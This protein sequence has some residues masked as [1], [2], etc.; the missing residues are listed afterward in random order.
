MKLQ[1]VSMVAPSQAVRRQ[2]RALIL[3]LTEGKFTLAELRRRLLELD[4]G[5]PLALY[6]EAMS[7]WDAGDLETA[8]DFMWRCLWSMPLD[9]RPL[10]GMYAL[11]LG[12]DQQ[13]TEELLVLAM[14]HYAEQAPELKIVEEL[15]RN[16]P[17][18]APVRLLL[19]DESALARMN[20]KMAEMRGGEAPELV[21]FWAADHL[22]DVMGDPEDE[23]LVERMLA[24]PE[25]YA[26]V[27]RGLCS[28]SGGEFNPGP[29]AFS[30]SSALA[31]LG[32]MGRMEDVPWVAERCSDE[33]RQ[34]RNT[35]IW[36][37][38]R[39]GSRQEREF[40][41]QLK[42]GVEGRNGWPLSALTGQ[43]WMRHG[44]RGMEP[45]LL[46]LLAGREGDEDWEYDFN[47]PPVV[48]ALLRLD[49]RRNKRVVREALK[50]RGSRLGEAAQRLVSELLSDE[51]ECNPVWASEDFV[52]APLKEVLF[53]DVLEILA[54]ES[55]LAQELGGGEEEYEDEY[56][57]DEVGPVAVARPGRNEPCWCGSGK[58]YK[59]C[60]LASDEAG[61]VEDEAALTS[62][63][64]RFAMENVR[65][66][67]MGPEM[68]RFGEHLP[69]DPNEM[70]DYFFQWLIY[71]YHCKPLGGSVVDTY[72]KRHAQSDEERALL[73][74][75]GETTVAVYEVQ[76]ARLDEGLELLD[77]MRQT[78]VFVH[79]T[80]TSR[81]LSRYDYLL[82]RLE[83]VDGQWL[84]Q[85]DLMSVPRTVAPEVLRRL[86]GEQRLGESWD[87]TLKRTAPELWRWVVDGADAAAKGLKFTTSTGEGLEM[88]RGVYEL[89]DEE[90]VKAALR[91]G[92][93]MHEEEGGT[94]AWV[95]P[96]SGVVLGYMRIR[97]E[98]MVVET[99]SRQRLE[100]SAALLRELAPGPELVHIKDEFEKVDLAK[101][102]EMP[103][104]APQPAESIAG[105]E[106][107]MMA[108]F[109]RHYSSWPDLE[110]PALD[111]RTPREAVKSA[112]G[113]A[114]VET[115]LRDF[116]NASAKEK[117]QGRTAYDFS[118][119]RRELG[120][121]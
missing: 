24:Q 88:C 53:E 64:M 118:K 49:R 18:D 2:C 16:L 115:L 86:R 95:E 51:M 6:G 90:G 112:E 69:P 21:P 59:K 93:M 15:T 96:E 81:K 4:P 13:F 20:E 107:M 10:F 52:Q 78:R 74:S 34:V 40:R 30:V 46:K 117:A 3:E 101:V 113:R 67:Q 60:H 104:K 32:E 76:E 11:T 105:A 72:R 27:L 36:A 75:W 84:F 22:S 17:A 5:H 116:E 82:A 41:E 77:V 57:D 44:Q 68:D 97:D 91:K 54:E 50:K 83:Q 65:P 85:G 38:T 35:A 33:D 25:V 94:F 29:G 99:M 114:A 48:D 8:R 71:D 70:P 55:E 61:E 119:L 98:R 111:G 109:E 89:L 37:L 80:T 47:L 19:A 23:E 121:E 12:E 92:E 120:M 1:T 39:I 42:L 45:L 63:L 102:R 103:A 108:Y 58:K 110:L 7:A 28:L 106:E 79:D 87:Q 66:E 31:V 14:R 9:F 56:E 73:K 100:R 26:G 43:L 62:R